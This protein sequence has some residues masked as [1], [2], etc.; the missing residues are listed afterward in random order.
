MAV[1]GTEELRVMLKN[2]AEELAEEYEQGDE[3]PDEIFRTIDNWFQSKFATGKITNMSSYPTGEYERENLQTMLNL[4]ELADQDAWV[5]EDSGLWEGM[6]GQ[7]VIFAQAFH[8]AENLLREY[9]PD[10]ID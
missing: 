2:E 6:E 8:S 5:T 10:D 7:Q 1:L 3:L 4:L 9:L